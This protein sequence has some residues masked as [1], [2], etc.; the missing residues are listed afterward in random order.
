[1]KIYKNFK[2]YPLEVPTFIDYAFRTDD[3]QDWYETVLKELDNG[4][5]KIAFE[6]DN[7]IRT[8]GYD[9]TGLYPENRSVTSIEEK[10]IPE[11]FA[12]NG[13]WMFDGEKIVPRIIPHEESLAKASGLKTYY[14][15]VATDAINPLQDAVDL[16]I[17]TAEEKRLLPLWK[18]YRVDVNRIDLSKAPDIIWPTPPAA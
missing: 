10:D 8:C 15:G 5:L 14:I 17:A 13:E 2:K 9:A 6:S 4:L 7:I 1:M 3:G 12:A 16:G 18:K 11:G